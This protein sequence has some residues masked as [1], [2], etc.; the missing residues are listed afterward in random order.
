MYR[1]K[2]DF[3]FKAHQTMIKGVLSVKIK[4]LPQGCVHNPPFYSPSHL[5]FHSPVLPCLEIVQT[6]SVRIFSKQCC[7]TSALCL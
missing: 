4:A 1:E 5:T 2:Y 7:S 3:V 6:V